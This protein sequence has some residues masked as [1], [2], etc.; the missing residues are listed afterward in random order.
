MKHTV[1]NVF[2]VS[3]FEK[4]LKGSSVTG[5]TQ[6]SLIVLLY[7]LNLITKKNMKIINK[8]GF[9]KHH[10]SHFGIN[11]YGFTCEIKSGKPKPLASD[12]IKWINFEEIKN[13]AFPKATLKLFDLLNDS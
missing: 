5:L 3:F 1:C 10:Y 6:D 13:Y 8:I 12:T 9:V 4:L 11:M 2:K 7:E